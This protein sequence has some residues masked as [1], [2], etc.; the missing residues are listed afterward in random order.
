MC[1]KTAKLGTTDTR[2]QWRKMKEYDAANNALQC[3]TFILKPLPGP[4]P[5]YMYYAIQIAERVYVMSIN[6]QPDVLGLDSPSI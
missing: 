3:Q 4:S 5:T 1:S 6:G 2:I